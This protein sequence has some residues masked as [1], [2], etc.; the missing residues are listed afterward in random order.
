MMMMMTWSWKKKVEVV[1][2]RLHRSSAAASQS[3]ACAVVAEGCRSYRC[4]SIQF[5]EMQRSYEGQR[6]WKRTMLRPAE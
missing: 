6:W 4:R 1:V 5:D 3:T 2:G